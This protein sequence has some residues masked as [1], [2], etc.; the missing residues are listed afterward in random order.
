MRRS[1]QQVR[2][3][4][5]SIR[6]GYRMGLAEPVVLAEVIAVRGQ[7]SSIGTNRMVLLSLH[8]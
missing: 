4:W 5:R 3:V 8:G 6:L 7:W 2:S 1:T